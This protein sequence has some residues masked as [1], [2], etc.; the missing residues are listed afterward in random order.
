MLYY[1]YYS[2][3]PLIYMSGHGHGGGGIGKV[4]FV[5]LLVIVAMFFVWYYTGGPERTDTKNPFMKPLA[6]ID[7][8]ETYG[9]GT[10][11]N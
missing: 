11:T 4:V 3:V 10:P 8:G 5:F 6:P 7:T 2:L 1:V 9:P